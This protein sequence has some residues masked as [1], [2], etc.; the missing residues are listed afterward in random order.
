[1]FLSP[2]FFNSILLFST[3]QQPLPIYLDSG[4]GNHQCGGLDIPFPFHLN[5]SGGPFRLSCVNDTTLYLNIGS[6]GYQLIDFMADGFDSFGFEGNSYYGI[7]IQNVFGLHGCED[8]SVCK[9]DVDHCVPSSQGNTFTACCYPLSDHSVWDVGDAFSV[10]SEFGCRGFSSWVGTKA[11]VKL[12]WAIPRNSSQGL[13]STNAFIVNATAVK[14]GVRC[15][16]NNG[17][18]G[19]G[20]AKGLG[21][22]QSCTKKGHGAYD[23]HCNTRP[24]NSKKVVLLA[25]FKQ[26]SLSYCKASKTRL[27][28]YKELEEATKGFH[29]GQKLIDGTN[30]T[31]HSGVLGDGLHV[32]VQKVPCQNEQNLMSVLSRVET[33]SQVLHRNVACIL[34]CCID[35]GQSLLVAYEFY[36]NG[37]LDEHLH[38]GGLDWHQRLHVAAETA[39]ALAYLQYEISPPIYHHDLKSACIFLD[40]DFSA[41]VAGFGLLNVDLI[42]VSEFLHQSD[43]Y[44]L[45]DLEFPEKW[46]QHNFGVVLLEI[47]SGSHK[48]VPALVLPKIRSGKLEEIVDPHLYYHEQPTFHREQIGV[49]ADLATRCLL[50]GGDGRLMDAA[51]EIVQIA[52]GSLEGGIR[53]GPALEE[54]FSNSSLLQMMSMSPD[55]IYLP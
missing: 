6:L 34:G 18:V 43:V 8:S 12:E 26:S 47:L 33:L 46:F 19:D 20:F 32:A 48:H 52:K 42:E 9:F 4:T 5:I 39:S 49:V 28:T 10:F 37:T 23:R 13:C 7:S 29:E 45:L 36:L 31:V 53:R 24:Y 50:F 44:N 38:R 3:F 21:C 2:L 27:F 14:T 40:E 11:G 55:S 35:A 1:M 54:T 25:G 51:R 16:C 17:F 15:A 41:E 30:G 22:L